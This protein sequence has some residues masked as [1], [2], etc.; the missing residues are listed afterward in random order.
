[1][2]KALWFIFGLM[3]GAGAGVGAS[4]SCF[5]RKYETESIDIPKDMN[6]GPVRAA[7]GISYEEI[8]KRRKQEV[9][10]KTDIPTSYR[11]YYAKT[12][13]YVS[14]VSP[15]NDPEEQERPPRTEPYRIDY[16]EFGNKEGFDTVSYSIYSDG[17]IT[18]ERDEA[19]T[20]DEV[21]DTF[22][23][24]ARNDA[25]G[26]DGAIYI[27]NEVHR[28]DYELVLNNHTY[29]EVLQETQPIVDGVTIM[30][31]VTQVVHTGEG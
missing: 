31:A 17:V 8:S 29:A 10:V 16:E 5:R 14:T 21:E 18:D 6:D 9:P 28:C 23:P 4:A 2:H 25:L 26:S 12:R 13:D 7:K 11:E 15:T 24:W 30:N 1:M 19:I 20:E 22:G 3:I 27:R